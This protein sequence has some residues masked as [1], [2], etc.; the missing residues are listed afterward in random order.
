MPAYDDKG[1]RVLDLP[2]DMIV[3]NRFSADANP[4]RGYLPYSTGW[5]RLHLEIPSSAEGKQLR[6]DFDGVQRV[7][8]GTQRCTSMASISV[9]IFV[10]TRL[11]VLTSPRR[12]SMAKT[13]SWRCTL[14]LPSQTAH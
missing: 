4:V 13:I 3:E 5:Y 12:C 7:L 6:L 10:A 14:T 2:H 8:S 1:W 11:L 9:L